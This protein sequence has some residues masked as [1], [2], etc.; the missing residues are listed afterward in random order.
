M[1]LTIWLI[2]TCLVLIDMLYALD[3]EPIAKIKYQE[4]SQLEQFGILVQLFLL[5]FIGSWFIII[6]RIVNQ[7]LIIYLHKRRK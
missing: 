7:I 4:L 1:I 3:N 5:A 2:G 6:W